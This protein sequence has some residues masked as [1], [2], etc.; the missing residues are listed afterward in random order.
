LVSKSIGSQP[1]VRLEVRY[2][3]VYRVTGRELREAGVDL[4][5]ISPN[6]L[7]L[8]NAGAMVPTLLKVAKPS[9]FS[10]SDYIEFLGGPPRGVYSYYMREN[11]FNV[12]HLTWNG[13]AGLRFRS[14]TSVDDARPAQSATFQFEEYRERDF[15]H[16]YSKLAPEITDNFYWLHFWAG[17]VPIQGYPMHMDFPGFDKSLGKPVELKFRMFGGTD[18]ATVKPNHRF[19]LHYGDYDLGTVEFDGLKYH[20]FETSIPASQIKPNLRVTFHTPPDRTNGIVD[21][22]SLDSIEVSYPRF[23]D[24]E[25]RDYFTFSN[26]LLKADNPTSHILVRGLKPGSEI[27]SLAEQVV[28]K[29]VSPETSGVVLAL[30][31]KPTTYVA[32]SPQGRM[33]VD[34]VSFRTSA[35]KDLADVSSGTEVLVLYHPLLTKSADLYNRFRTSQGM[36]VKSVNVQDICDSLNHGYVSD[37]AL[38]AYIRYAYAQSPQLR[39]V[40]LLGDSTFDYREAQLF[41]G[42]TPPKVLI[43][44]HWVNNPSTTWSGGYQ[45][46]NW[47]GC[48]GDVYRPDV[49]V[50]RISAATEAQGMDYVRKVIEH[51]TADRHSRNKALLISS[52]EKSF[53]ELVEEIAQKYAREFTTV[54]LLYPETAQ[55]DRDVKRLCDEFDSDVQLVYYVGH[56]GS[57]VWRVGPVDFQRQKDLFT[58]ADVARLNNAGKYPIILCSSCYTTSFDQSKSLGEALLLSAERGGIALIGSPWKATVQ[59]SHVFNSQVFNFYFKDGVK[60]LGDACLLAHQAIT[61]AGQ[62]LPA[63]QSFTLLGDPCLTIPKAQPTTAP[64]VAAPMANRPKPYEMRNGR[65]FLLGWDDQAVTVPVPLA[66]LGPDAFAKTATVFRNRVVLKDAPIVS[67]PIDISSTATELALNGRSRPDEDLFPLISV[68]LL[69][70]DDHTTYTLFSGFAQSVSIQDLT[71][72]LPKE[73]RGKRVQLQLEILNPSALNDVRAYYLAR[74]EIR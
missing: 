34:S 54:S 7:A 28:Y 61:P 1:Y 43:P 45:D 33:R 12:Y 66:T 10:D 26:A 38:K 37:T 47:Y 55:A 9:S 25:G 21:F 64:Q 52:V 24:A 67:T 16:R 2:T 44:I 70:A 42:D 69:S 18:I 72:P 73:V 19:A 3:G 68:S 30:S 15:Q 39:Y 40:V 65:V 60:R 58:P 41:D 23:Y 56:G 22:V 8:W 27:F 63:Y 36:H 57:F 59:E 31:D 74:A 14:E 17:Q 62:V 29:G 6:R 50:G 5:Q 20:T 4:S 53:Q 11:L 48:L 35:A 32:V 51:E 49:S 13:P 46:D 71:I